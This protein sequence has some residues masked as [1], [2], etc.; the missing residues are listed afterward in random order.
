MNRRKHKIQF[1]NYCVTGKQILSKEETKEGNVSWRTYGS[2]FSAA[3][4]PLVIGTAVCVAVAAEGCRAF[5]YWGLGMWLA[6]GRGVSMGVTRGVVK[7]SGTEVSI[8]ARKGCLRG[9]EQ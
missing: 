5:S 7:R 3:G 6:D 9:Q 2:Y 1:T 4:G 8:R